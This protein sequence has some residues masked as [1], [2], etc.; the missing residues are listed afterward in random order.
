[1]MHRN[2]LPSGDQRNMHSRSRA[3]QT[4]RVLQKPCPSEMRGRREGRVP[5]APMAPVRSKKH[6]V[7]TTGSDGINRPSLHNG[8][9]AYSA[10]SPGTGLDCPRHLR[11][12]TANLASASGGQD[13]APL[14]S[15]S[16]SFVRTRSCASLPR[17]S[18]PA[19]RV[20][21]IA[22]RPSSSRRDG[23]TKSQHSEKRKHYFLKVPGRT[24]LP[25]NGLTN[26]VCSVQAKSPQG[27]ATTPQLR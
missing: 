15:A 3:R 23:A 22:I 17:P 21:T 12:V 11:I 8:F 18:H 5:A 2:A 10:L 16:A 7:G 19:S 24:G 26:F 4:H 9:T 13:H 1:M 25:L 14:P 6:G 20:V 27:G